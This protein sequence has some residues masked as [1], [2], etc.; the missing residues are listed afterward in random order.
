MTIYHI[1]TSSICPIT[2]TLHF[3]LHLTFMTGD[4]WD[5]HV[6]RG[7]KASKS[8]TAVELTFQH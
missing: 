7:V 2:F 4:E 1:D 5:S 3:F 8:V 6:V